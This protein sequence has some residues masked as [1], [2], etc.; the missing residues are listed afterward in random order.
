M[1]LQEAQRE[2]YSQAVTY[3]NKAI[4]NEAAMRSINQG[5]FDP[6]FLINRGDFYR[7]LQKYEHAAMDYQEALDATPGNKELMK[8]LSYVRT[9]S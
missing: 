8:K 6:R 2:N 5:D 7:R 3:I 4:E 1:A 9:R